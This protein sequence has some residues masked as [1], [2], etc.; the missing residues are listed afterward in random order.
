MESIHRDGPPNGLVR[1]VEVD[2]NDATILSF[3][4]GDIC[5]YLLKGDHNGLISYVSL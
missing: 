4:G 3:E 1:L 5:I 2:D